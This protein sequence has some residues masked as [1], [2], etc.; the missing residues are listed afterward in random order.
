MYNEVSLSLTIVQYVI[1][2]ENRDKSKIKNVTNSIEVTL[3]VT[4]KFFCDLYGYWTHLI[5][6]YK[7]IDVHPKQ[8]H[9][10]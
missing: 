9:K 4:A 2:S 3:V 6:Q 7:H 10:S 5:E 8:T 1:N